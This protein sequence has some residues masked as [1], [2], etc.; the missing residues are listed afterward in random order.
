MRRQLEVVAAKRILLI[1]QRLILRQL[2]AA[3]RM[4]VMVEDHFL[5]E[6]VKFHGRIS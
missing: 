6:I 5:I 3:P 1:Y 4:T 2:A